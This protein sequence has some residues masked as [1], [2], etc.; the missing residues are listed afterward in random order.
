VRISDGGSGLAART[1]ARRLSSISE[2]FAYLRPLTAYPVDPD[3]AHPAQAS[4]MEKS[5][6]SRTMSSSDRPSPRV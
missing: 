4:E 1:V 6:G 5:V 3:T 2:L